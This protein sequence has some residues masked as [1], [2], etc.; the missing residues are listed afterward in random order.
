L[1]VVTVWLRAN[2]TPVTLVPVEMN[3]ARIRCSPSTAAIA[4]PAV[5]VATMK[6]LPVS[7]AVASVIRLLSPLVPPAL[8]VQLAAAP[9]M[10]EVPRCT[11]APS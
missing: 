11:D 10:Q 8:V 3:S 7:T 9:P 2:W 1:F 4:L 6:D 5:E